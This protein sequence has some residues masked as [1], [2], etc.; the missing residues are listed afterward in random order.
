VRG[1]CVLLTKALY[2]PFSLI[3]FMNK[4]NVQVTLFIILGLV[5]LISIAFIVTITLS[6]MEINGAST[7]TDDPVKPLEMYVSSCIEHT[8]QNAILD[9]S[10]TGGYLVLPAESTTA[11]DVDVPFYLYDGTDLKPNDDRIA[12]EIA[13]YIDDNIDICLDNFAAFAGQGINITADAPVTS[14]TLSIHQLMVKTE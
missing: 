8:A 1:V 14:A 11:L 5:I 9:N 12:S 10:Y 7:A 13:D 4:R 6:R 2:I 3:Y